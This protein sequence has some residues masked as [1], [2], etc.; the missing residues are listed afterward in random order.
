MWEKA[1]IL[2]YSQ[3]SPSAAVEENEKKLGAPYGAAEFATFGDGKK[4]WSDWS[5]PNGFKDFRRAMRI[6]NMCLVLKLDNEELVSIANEQTESK[7]E[8]QS[9][10]VPY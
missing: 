4:N 8:S 3:N 1:S 7:T 9:H 10:P 6:P 2:R 5:T